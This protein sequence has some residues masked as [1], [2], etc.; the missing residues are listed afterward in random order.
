MKIEH[1]GTCRFFYEYEAKGIPATGSRTQ[2]AGFGECCLNPPSF[3]LAPNYHTRPVEYGLEQRRPR[4]DAIDGCGQ[5]EPAFAEV[6]EEEPPTDEKRANK[7]KAADR[8]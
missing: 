1:C 4:M 2:R 7:K 8:D 3:V 6:D 5:H